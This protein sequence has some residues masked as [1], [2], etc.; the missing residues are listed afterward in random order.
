MPLIKI[1]GMSKLKFTVL[2]LQPITLLVKLQRTQ[3][4]EQTGATL[5]DGPTLKS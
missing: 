5:H 3:H 4:L 1:T 2:S